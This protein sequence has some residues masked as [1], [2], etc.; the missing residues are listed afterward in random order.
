MNARKVILVTLDNGLEYEDRDWD[1]V[2]IY[3]IDQLG[4]AR[5]DGIQELQKLEDEWY[6]DAS[7]SIR[8]VW[9]N[10]LLDYTGTLIEKIDQRSL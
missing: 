1:I 2:G 4:K 9:I 7:I 10:K 8:K 6:R 5:Q 3:S